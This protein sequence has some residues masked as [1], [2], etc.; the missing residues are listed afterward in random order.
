MGLAQA[1][2][3]KCEV[4]DVYVLDVRK[5]AARAAGY[6]YGKRIMYID[7]QSFGAL[8]LDLY[9]RA[10][11]KWKI[12]LLQPIVLPLP[13]PGL[14]NSTGAWFAHFR[15]LRKGDWDKGSVFKQLR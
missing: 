6:C 7:R 13:E 5:L 3:G 2:V 9:D 4:R 11:Q 14:Q 10:M 12:A 8:W 1:I 15:D